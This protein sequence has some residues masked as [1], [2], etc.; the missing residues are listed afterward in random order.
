MRDAIRRNH[1]MERMVRDIR[2]LLDAD[3][4]DQE[5]NVLYLWDDD[6]GTVTS[7]VSYTEFGEDD[8]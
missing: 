4:Q 7:G 2:Y 5:V 1:V 6:G 3:D 8:G